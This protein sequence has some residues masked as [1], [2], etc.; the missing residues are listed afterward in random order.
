MTELFHD[1]QEEAYSVKLPGSYFGVVL[2]PF[3]WA[4]TKGQNFSST[5]RLLTDD[6]FAVHTRVLS[7]YYF[8]ASAIRKVLQNDIIDFFL[9]N[10]FPVKKNQVSRAMVYP[11]YD[12]NLQT[13]SHVISH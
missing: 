9:G 2:F 6:D 1:V 7:S 11:C 5:R 3:K 12:C 4:S 8:Q 10:I 13:L